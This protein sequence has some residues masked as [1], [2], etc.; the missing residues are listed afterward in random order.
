MTASGTRIHLD[1][2][3]ILADPK[4][5][6][7][8]RL[9]RG[10]VV[11]FPN[12]ATDKQRPRHRRP[13]TRRQHRDS[14]TQAAV[15]W[16]LVRWPRRWNTASPQWHKPADAAMPKRPAPSARTTDGAPFG[17]PRPLWDPLGRCGIPGPSLPRARRRHAAAGARHEP[18]RTRT[19][20]TAVEMNC[21]LAHACFF[22][23]APDPARPFSF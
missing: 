18:N 14:A 20:D 6:E 3:S 11:M 4:L 7:M 22:S 12:R 2:G 1:M 5:G 23:S 10:G 13:I 8:G 17:G 15:C 16:P 19:H 9:A 21:L